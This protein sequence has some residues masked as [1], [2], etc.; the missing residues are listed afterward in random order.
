MSA[1]K[2]NRR[3]ANAG[4]RSRDEGKKE[5]RKEEGR[6]ERERESEAVRRGGWSTGQ[7]DRAAERYERKKEI[8]TPGFP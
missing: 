3:S 6:R 2:L 5:G 8:L 7:M 4:A 1:R